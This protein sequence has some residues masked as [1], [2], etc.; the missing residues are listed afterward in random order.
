MTKDIKKQKVL[1]IDNYDS[2]TYNLVQYLGELNCDLMVYRNDKITIS[3]IRGIDPDKLVISPGPGT[4]DDSG[5]SRELIREFTGK[6]PILGICLGM[7]T[8][9]DVYGA[10]VVRAPELRHGKT[11]PVS[12]EEDSLFAGIPSPFEAT[13]Y[14]SLIVEKSSIP[15][16]LEITASTE[17]GLVMALKV[18]GTGTLGVQFHPESIKTD[19][20]K[21]L[22]ENFLC[23]E[24]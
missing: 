18:K 24:N 14:H 9:G 17:D 3:E 20:G 5:I 6:K 23:Y 12:H 7:Q 19:H 10:D 22:L 1:V 16:E 15:D 4:P 11:S 2:F 21:K 13:R 8:I